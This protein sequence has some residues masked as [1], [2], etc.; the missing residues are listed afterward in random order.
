M[1]NSMAIRD[2]WD[3]EH[4]GCWCI[5]KKGYGPAVDEVDFAC[6]GNASFLNQ[7]DFDWLATLHQIVN[8]SQHTV[9]AGD[10][11]KLSMETNVTDSTH[12]TNGNSSKT[13]TLV[14]LLISNA[15]SVSN[16]NS[17]LTFFLGFHPN[18]T[19]FNVTSGT[20][21]VSSLDN[22]YDVTSGKIKFKLETSDL[23]CCD[24]LQQ[25]LQ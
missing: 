20:P 13:L 22:S 8:L 11:L 19:S 10:V 4:Y 2:F 1:I 6:L 18:L 21:L 17:S 14:L 15:V 12:L 9:N 25:T 16:N 3:F 7:S 24:M 23:K 5:E